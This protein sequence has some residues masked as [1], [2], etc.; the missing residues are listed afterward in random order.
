[1][2]RAI[3]VTGLLLSAAVS[4]APTALAVRQV[5]HISPVIDNWTPPSYKFLDDS[6]VM[7]FARSG[8]G[9][10]LYWYAC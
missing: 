8:G 3:F 2:K 6:C 1:M 4:F 10:Y 7:F 5:S 9:Y